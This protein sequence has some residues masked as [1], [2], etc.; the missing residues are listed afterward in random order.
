[1]CYDEIIWHSNGLL[2]LHKINKSFNK[3]YEIFKKIHDIYET[4][5]DN[6]LV[7]DIVQLI[8]PEIF[9]RNMVF[10]NFICNYNHN[11]VLNLQ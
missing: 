2:V 11:I 5:E 4:L 7:N 6:L 8:C 3:V 9:D 10:L 1:M